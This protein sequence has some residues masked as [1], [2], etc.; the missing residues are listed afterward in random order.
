[1]SRAGEQ[2]TEVGI[3]R[4]YLFIGLGMKEDQGLLNILKLIEEGSDSSAV[5]AVIS[6]VTLAL[7]HK[8]GTLKE[9][10]RAALDRTTIP[11]HQT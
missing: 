4:H 11:G 1:M 5:K 3:L 6:L 8:I 9:D 7:A 2:Q 10:V